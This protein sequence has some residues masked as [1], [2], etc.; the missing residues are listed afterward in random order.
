MP[1]LSPPQNSLWLFCVG[2]PEKKVLKHCGEIKVDEGLNAEK[3]SV[4]VAKQILCAVKCTREGKKFGNLKK[5]E[6]FCIA[7][8]CANSRNGKKRT[9]AR[10]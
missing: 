9:T 4:K 2:D 7:F 1:P 10:E 8:G 6:L 3:C 5:K